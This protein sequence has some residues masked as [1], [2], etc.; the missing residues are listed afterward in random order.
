M[1]NPQQMNTELNRRSADV[2][3]S[4]EAMMQI[5]DSTGGK[6][7]YNRNDIDHAVAL[8]IADGST[9]YTL[10]YYPADKDWNGKFRKVEIKVDRP[11]TQVRYR[12]GYY[13]TDPLASSHMTK[14]AVQ[15]E[16]GTALGDPLPSTMI[17]LFGSAFKLVPRDQLQSTTPAPSA[18]PAPPEGGNNNPKPQLVE[19][20]KIAVRFLVE[21][22]GITMQKR[23]DAQ[24]MSI[25]FAVAAF[26]GDK[27][28]GQISQTVEGNPKPETI[29]KLMQQGILF[30]TSL[31]V[32]KGNCR[33]RLLVHDN[34]NGRIGTVDI[35]ITDA[36][37]TVQ[38]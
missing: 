3:A 5:A 27:V 11:G 18:A 21:T 13:A 7:Y 33:L 16:I 19:R 17:T 30:N 8:S 34:L 1:M 29:N 2:T 28:I 6:A 15:R 37:Q 12:H 22:A 32:P 31:M 20:Q 25:D 4:H 10:A 14:Q 38:E 24:H 35:P 23:G 26:R 9:Y 36:T